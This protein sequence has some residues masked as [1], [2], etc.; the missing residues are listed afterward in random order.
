MRRSAQSDRRIEAVAAD[1][2]GASQ[3]VTGDRGTQFGKRKS[4]LQATVRDAE[5]QHFEVIAMHALVIPRRA[6]TVV[7]AI[8]PFHRRTAPEPAGLIA[9]SLF[10]AAPPARCLLS[11]GPLA[12]AACQG[13]VTQYWSVWACAVPLQKQT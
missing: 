11:L 12:S 13:T 7:P 8:A 10:A 1:Q 6:R 3:H 2:C 5:R 9:T 4:S